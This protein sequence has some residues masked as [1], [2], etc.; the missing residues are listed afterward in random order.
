[1][2]LMLRAMRR[3][4]AN[5]LGV[6]PPPPE[7]EKLYAAMLLLGVTAFFVLLAAFGWFL[8]LHIYTS[9]AGR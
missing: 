6:T 3:V 8:F 5:Y 9:V 1:M 2:E 4:F 7:K